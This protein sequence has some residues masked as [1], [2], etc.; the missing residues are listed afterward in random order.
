VSKELFGCSDAS[1]LNSCSMENTL[2]MVN[3]AMYQSDVMCAE[4]VMRALVESPKKA[5]R[6]LGVG[7]VNQYMIAGHIC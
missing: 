7:G 2:D 5:V 4:S 3:C 1:A 6:K